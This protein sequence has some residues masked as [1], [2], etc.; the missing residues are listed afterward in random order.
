MRCASGCAGAC[1]PRDFLYRLHLVV[2]FPGHSLGSLA[3]YMSF[4]HQRVFGNPKLDEG[5]DWRGFW[6]KRLMRIFPGLVVAVAFSVFALG[7]AVTVLV[8]RAAVLACTGYLD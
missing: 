1:C 5:P 7:W 2:P 6:I 8:A 3:V 4:L